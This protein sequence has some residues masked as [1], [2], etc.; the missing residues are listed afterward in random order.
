MGAGRTQNSRASAVVYRKSQLFVTGRYL[1]PLVVLV[2]MLQNGSH[3]VGR[4]ICQHLQVKG[5]ISTTQHRDPGKGTSSHNPQMDS[6][7]DR[8]WEGNSS[9]CYRSLG[10]LS[11]FYVEVAW[12]FQNCW[13]YP[14]CT[15]SITQ[16]TFTVPTWLNG[17]IIWQCP[18]DDGQ[19]W[20]HDHLVSWTHA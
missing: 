3:I 2:L 19:L 9:H 11:D 1:I 8:K 20:L 5:G 10:N 13:P 4:K 6:R 15:I 12:A 7:Q 18:F 14:E 16:S 17:P